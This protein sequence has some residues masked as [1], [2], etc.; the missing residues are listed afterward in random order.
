MNNTKWTEIFKLFY[1]GVE[2]SSNPVPICWTTRTIDGVLYRDSTWSHFGVDMEGFKKIDWLRID[3][4]PENRTVVLNILET[5]HVPGE[6]CHDCVY[7]YGYRTD[8]D[9]IE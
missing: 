6:I 9:Y 4:T 2:C 5:V 3:L 8:V 7:I 1:Y